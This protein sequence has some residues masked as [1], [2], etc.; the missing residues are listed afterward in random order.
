MD[1]NG[2]SLPQKALEV[3][4]QLDIRFVVFEGTLF[5]VERNKR[6]IRSPAQP[7]FLHTVFTGGPTPRSKA[8][9]FSQLNKGD[10]M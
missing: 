7:Y 8:L 9:V 10:T 3:S 1:R 6:S 4:R 5:E 2:L